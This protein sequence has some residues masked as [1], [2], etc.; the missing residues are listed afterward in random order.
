[1]NV[2]TNPEVERVEVPLSWRFAAIL[3]GIM[4]CIRMR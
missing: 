1:M 2:S 3:E 4:K